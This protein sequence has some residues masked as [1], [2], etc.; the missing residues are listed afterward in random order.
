MRHQL[1]RLIE[2]VPF[3]IGKVFA[4][5][6]FEYRLGP[7]YRR[8][9]ELL[10][11]TWS[12]DDTLQYAVHRFAKIF[13]FAKNNF[14]FY[15]ELYISAGV[16]DLQIQSLEDIKRVPTVTKELLRDHVSQFN[17][18]IK[19]NT[20]GTMGSPLTFYVDKNAFAREWAHMHFIWAKAG[21]TYR[22]LK[23]TFRGKNL[24]NRLLL[25]N[26][27]HNEFLVNTYAPP[28][29]C[30][31]AVARIVAKYNIRFIHGYPSTIYYF[32]T[33]VSSSLTDK[34]R[35]T[36]KR[37]LEVCLL[38]SEFPAPHISHYLKTDWGLHCVSWYG[39]SE[40]AILAYD[41]RCQNIYTCLHTYGLP[42]VVRG[43]HLVGTSFHNRDMPLIRYETGD[44]V[45]G[46]FASNGLLETLSIDEGRE[47]DYIVDMKG[48]RISLTALIFG[49]HHEIFNHADFVQVTQGPDNIV[50]LLVSS[51]TLTRPEDALRLFDLTNVAADFR[52]ELHDKPI[53]TAAG[54]TPLKLAPREYAQHFE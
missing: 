52:V 12:D 19:L 50:T 22:D 48:T 17:G 40:M 35:N 24:G 29:Q 16:F 7:E 1:K 9:S 11:Q 30:I 42:E 2:N 4:R 31:D 32:L 49:R 18:A 33:R 6:P 8:F 38:G 13:E 51:R 10:K 34:D 14:P 25:Y 53:R 46:K 54:K 26:P 20:G 37:H 41:V 36:L 45:D 23:L 3:F 5:F 39:H 44:L 21:Y 27:V 47:G 43:N 15:R 28:E